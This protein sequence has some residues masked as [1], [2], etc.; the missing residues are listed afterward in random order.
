MQP[1]VSQSQATRVMHGPI[2]DAAPQ[3]KTQASDE[4]CNRIADVRSGTRAPEGTHWVTKA[5]HIGDRRLR[6]LRVTEA[7]LI[8]DLSGRN[9]WSVWSLS[10]A[11]AFAN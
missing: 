11:I 7:T 3:A 1:T 10:S 5:T 4:R 6:A 8:G 2:K 9:V